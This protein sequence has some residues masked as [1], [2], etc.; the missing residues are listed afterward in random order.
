[1]KVDVYVDRE[2]RNDYV[3]TCL[4]RDFYEVNV[5]LKEDDVKF[6]VV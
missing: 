4:K 6:L 5:I 3:K 1:M 2:L